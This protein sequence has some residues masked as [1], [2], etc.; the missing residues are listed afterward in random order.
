[1]DVLER[2]RKLESAIREHADEAER[3]RRLPSTLVDELRDAGAFRLAMPGEWGGPDFTSVQQT[4]VVEQVSRIDA[5]VGWCVMIGMDSG[6]Y[7]RYLDPTVARE[8]FPRLDM[9]TAGWLLPAGMAREV[10]GGYLVDGHWRFGSGCTHADWIVGGCTVYRDDKP[11]TG[12]DGRPLWRIVM[13]EASAFTILDTWHT[14]GLA[15]TGSCDYTA[16]ELFVPGEHTFSFDSPVHPGPLTRRP[17]A[18]NRKMAG[19]PLGAARAALDY[20]YDVAEHRRERPS[21]VRWPDSPRIQQAVGDCERRLLSARSLVYDSLEELWD[22][23][24]AGWEPDARLRAKVALARYGAF[25]AAREIVAELYDLIG[26]ESVYASRTPLDR[27]HRD[28]M[29][30]CQ[31]VVAQRRS[32]EHAGQLLLGGEPDYPFI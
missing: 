17:E 19:V 5:S 8:A 12:A 21:G 32:V 31:H 2:L 27:I 28:L 9:V 4:E 23:L 6:I 13:A 10:D 11:V 25:Q 14:T 24:A 18:I 22:C 30:A 15:G 29:T 26:G 7:A 20:V 3:S 16:T 1:M